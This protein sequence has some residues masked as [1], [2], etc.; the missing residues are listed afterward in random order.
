VVVVVTAAVVGRVG[1][2]EP[3]PL[4]DGV[5]REVEVAVLLFESSALKVCLG[6]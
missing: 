6:C 1:M 5:G 2:V 4:V 3:P